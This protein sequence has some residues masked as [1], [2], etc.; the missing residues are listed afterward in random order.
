M[1]PLRG[2]PHFEG[3]SKN[4]DKR[5]GVFK[6]HETTVIHLDYPKN[7]CQNA[8]DNKLLRC[9][10][11]KRGLAMRGDNFYESEHLVVI[12]ETK[13]PIFFSQAKLEFNANL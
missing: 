13:K 7:M 2:T 6:M 11:F 12:A 5:N 1:L 8:F 9:S 4:K 10:K 3:H